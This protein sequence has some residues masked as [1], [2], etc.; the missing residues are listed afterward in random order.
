MSDSGLLR[1]IERDRRLIE[2]LP[3]GQRAALKHEV[4]RS[5]RNCSG[6][7]FNTTRNNPKN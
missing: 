7:S 5:T 4:S 2:A 6:Y 1:Q 3:Q